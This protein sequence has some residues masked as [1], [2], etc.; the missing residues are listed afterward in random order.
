MC[1][2]RMP[3]CLGAARLAPAACMPAQPPQLCAVFVSWYDKN[4]DARTSGT[5]DGFARRVQPGVHPG[6][7]PCGTLANQGADARCILSD[8]GS[9]HQRIE[10]AQRRRQRP[11]C[12]TGTVD[13]QRNRLGRPRVGALQQRRH[14]A[15]YLRHP[16]QT[17]GAVVQQIVHRLGGHLPP[18]HQVQND[19]R[20]KRPTARAHHQTIERRKSHGGGDA[21]PRIHRAQAGTAAQMRHNRA[22]PPPGAC[23][24][25]ASTW[26]CGGCRL[27]L[28]PI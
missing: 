3:R 19:G 18:L 15:R 20:V 10:A 8:T 17:G 28:G 22:A 5:D 12:P 11:D 23:S 25:P 2:G 14:V 21:L 4:F 7:P 26:P 6:T 24:R 9:E 1:L 13:E 27:K 16:Q